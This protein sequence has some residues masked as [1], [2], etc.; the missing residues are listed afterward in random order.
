MWSKDNETKDSKSKE[1]ER[2]VEE[3]NHPDTDTGAY[4]D[5]SKWSYLR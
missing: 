2:K 1:K 4:L 5:K 3:D